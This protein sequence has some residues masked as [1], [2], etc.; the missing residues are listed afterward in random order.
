MTRTSFQCSRCSLVFATEMRLKSHACSSGDQPLQARA[1]GSVAASARKP[2]PT[3][4]VIAT[5][6]SASPPSPDLPATA[7]WGYL[8][9]RIGQLGCLELECWGEV[10]VDDRDPRVGTRLA[11]QQCWGVVGLGRG[12]PLASG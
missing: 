4:W 12:V 9:H 7:G 2:Q 8:V 5:D 10:L 1:A 3:A 11:H 6:G